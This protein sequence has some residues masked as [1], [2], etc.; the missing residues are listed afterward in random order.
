[1]CALLLANV[2]LKLQP[3]LF[4]SEY[5][6]MYH[7]NIRSDMRMIHSVIYHPTSCCNLKKF[8]GQMATFLKTSS[9]DYLFG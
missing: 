9:T 8:L 5:F 3:N 7:E 6:I 4:A 2:S 1:M